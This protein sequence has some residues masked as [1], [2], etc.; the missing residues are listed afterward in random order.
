MTM[1]PKSFPDNLNI[2][3]ILAC[4]WKFFSDQC[5]QFPLTFTE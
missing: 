2:E 5:I 4:G 1:R 3:L